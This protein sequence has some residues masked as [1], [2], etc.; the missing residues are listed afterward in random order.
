MLVD[1]EVNCAGNQMN[2][3][4][5]RLWYEELLSDG[6]VKNERVLFIRNIHQKDALKTYIKRSWLWALPCAR[7]GLTERGGAEGAAENECTKVFYD[8]LNF[9]AR[10]CTS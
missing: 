2:T 3:R 10:K 4:I 8:R 1:F 6:E 7:Y 5:G 9:D